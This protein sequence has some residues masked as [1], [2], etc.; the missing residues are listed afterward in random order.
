MPDIDSLMQAWDP[1]FER[2]LEENPLPESELDIPI[3]DL[4]RYACA[5]LDIPIYDQNKEKS[6]IEAMHVMFGLYSAFDQHFTSQNGEA[7]EIGRAH[8]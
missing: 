6:V 2:I 3:E 7:K 8:V 1:E 4:A 5:M